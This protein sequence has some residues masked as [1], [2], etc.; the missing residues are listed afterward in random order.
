MMGQKALE[1]LYNIL[2]GFGIII[3]MDFLKYNGQ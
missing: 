3:N 1:L 2:L